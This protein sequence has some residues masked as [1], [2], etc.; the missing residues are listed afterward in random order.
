MTYEYWNILNDSSSYQHLICYHSHKIE[1]NLTT[2]VGKNFF[3]FFWQSSLIE[4]IFSYIGL[5][6]LTC[7]KEV[8]NLGHSATP[9]S[10]SGNEVFL[11]NCA[12][13]L[14]NIFQTS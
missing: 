7:A 10:I 2:K 6:P 8:L 13:A 3:F 1:I 11:C 14:R 5:N 4:L 9:P 12:W